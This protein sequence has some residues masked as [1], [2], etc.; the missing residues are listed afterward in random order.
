[1]EMKIPKTMAENTQFEMEVPIMNTS[2]CEEIVTETCDYHLTH[3]KV[4]SKIIS[5]QTYNYMDFIFLL[6]MWRKVCKTY[7]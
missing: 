7:K 6:L 4:M 5:C 2:S 1:M 3:E